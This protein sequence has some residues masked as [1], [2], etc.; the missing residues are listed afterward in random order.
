MIVIFD[1]IR[2]DLMHRR[3][4]ARRRDVQRVLRSR[5][6]DVDEREQRDNGLCERKIGIADGLEGEIP[7]PVQREHRLDD[8]R[9]AEQEA[10]L[11]GR[12]RHH[13]HQRIAQRV[14]E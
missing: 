3:F 9:A 12:Q 7:E 1:T 2:A 6:P 5:Q 14:A 10:Q 4:F 8:H 13:R 11:D